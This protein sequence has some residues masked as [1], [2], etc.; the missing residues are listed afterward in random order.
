MIFFHPEEKN[1][2]RYITALNSKG[3]QPLTKSE[4]CA[5]KAERTTEHCG[6][7]MKRPFGDTF[8]LEKMPHHTNTLN[9]L[10]L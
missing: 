2:L 3:L 6:S 10:Y 8:F 7:L 4:P 5:V 1:S 9:G